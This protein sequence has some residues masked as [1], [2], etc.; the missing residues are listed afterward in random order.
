M[1]ARE[2]FPLSLENTDPGERERLMAQETSQG[3][4]AGSR[5]QRSRSEWESL[6]GRGVGARPGHLS[7]WGLEVQRDPI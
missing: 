4:A 5:C 7:V 3:R 6:K 2:S 1:E